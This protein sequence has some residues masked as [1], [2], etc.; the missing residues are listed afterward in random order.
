MQ[1]ARDD[2]KSKGKRRSD[3][4]RGADSQIVGR[5]GD[6]SKEMMTQHEGETETRMTTRCSRETGREGDATT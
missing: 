1:L 2:G 4:E 5:S 6:T 3:L